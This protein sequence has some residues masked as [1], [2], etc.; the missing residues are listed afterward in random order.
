[1]PY[2]IDFTD[3]HRLKKGYPGAGCK[4][5]SVEYNGEIYM[6]KFPGAVHQYSGISEYIG[7]HVYESIG[8]RVQ[9]TV[10]GTYR[11]SPDKTWLVA[12]C[13]D[14]TSVGVIL[15][16]FAS[17]RNQVLISSCFAD[18]NERSTIEMIFKKENII[19]Q[20]ILRQRFWDMF[21]V[22]ALICNENRTS[23]NWGF[24]YNTNSDKLTLA[25]IY[26]CGRCLYPQADEKDIKNALLNPE[27]LHRHV[28]S[29]KSAV[30]ENGEYISCFDYIKS[31]RNADCTQAL[32]RI[33]PRID[34]KAI[35]GIVDGTPYISV[36]RK[37]FIKAVLETSYN[38][39][40]HAYD[41][42]LL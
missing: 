22:D 1:M 7:C 37:V 12:A 17:F 8:L 5:L 35:H 23:E 36:Q 40:K 19:D 31:M 9:K 3:C 14:F 6:L 41:L 18:S 27:E 2:T 33:Y 10:L 34:I 26:S 24:L 30:K 32:K 28:R 39:L 11:T 13:R 20:Q 4:K 29:L 38:E 15:Q 42:I 25:P 21:I 16:D